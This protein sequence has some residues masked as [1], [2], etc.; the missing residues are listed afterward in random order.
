M[1]R[2]I[3]IFAPVTGSG[4]GNFQQLLHN[5]LR[6]FFGK[7]GSFPHQFNPIGNPAI[8]FRGNEAQAVMGFVR[9]SNPKVTRELATTILSWLSL[10]KTFLRLPGCGITIPG[11]FLSTG[12][13]HF[14]RGQNPK[15][16]AEGTGL[17]RFFVSWSLT[18]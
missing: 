14:P 9:L 11:P 8:G 10:K 15:W 7:A 6:R 13:K 16:K 4:V 17:S 1:I 5:S 3:P 2:L 12:R 18:G